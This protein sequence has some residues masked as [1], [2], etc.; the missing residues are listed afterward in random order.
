MSMIPRSQP[1]ISI[2]MV[3]TKVEDD[4]NFW[5]N[6]IKFLGSLVFL[7]YYTSAEISGKIC[8]TYFLPR[9]KKAIQVG[10]LQREEA[11]SWTGLKY[12]DYLTESRPDISIPTLLTI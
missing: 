3:K 11:Q 7:W 2:S 5:G 12:I 10:Y 6:F 8:A 4:D 9:I 1:K